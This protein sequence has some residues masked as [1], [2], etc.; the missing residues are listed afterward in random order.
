MP[1][2]GV[3]T[4]NGVTPSSLYIGATYCRYW[5]FESGLPYLKKKTN[6]ITFSKKTNFTKKNTAMGRKLWNVVIWQYK[7]TCVKCLTDLT[8]M[9]R[10]CHH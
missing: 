7:N 2:I 6:S 9:T 10:I 3:S 8:F 4:L 5:G 1:G